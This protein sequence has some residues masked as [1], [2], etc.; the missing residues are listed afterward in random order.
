MGRGSTKG[1]FSLHSKM[2]SVVLTLKV[3]YAASSIPHKGKKIIVLLYQGIFAYNKSA[4]G[5]SWY[6]CTNSNKRQ[7]CHSMI[8]WNIHNCNF[9]SVFWK[10][11]LSRG[12][13]LFFLL[14]RACSSNTFLIYKKVLFFFLSEFAKDLCQC[15]F[16]NFFFLLL[17]IGEILIFI[18]TPAFWALIKLRTIAKN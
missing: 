10:L 17:G 5:L 11:K 3:P 8:L 13:C 14:T 15:W 12:I 16:N 18:P 2:S 4:K 1:S 7:L 9:I 6:V